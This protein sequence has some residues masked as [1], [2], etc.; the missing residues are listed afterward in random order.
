LKKTLLAAA[1]VWTLPA[2]AAEPTR[3]LVFNIM[4]SGHQIGQH[5]IDITTQ[6]KNTTVDMKTDIEVK[7]MF[8]TA[9][10]LTYTA[11]ETWTNGTFATFQSQTDDNGKQH[12]VTVTATAD[13][14][15]V[16]ADG[17]RAE[18]PKGTLPATFWNTQFLTRKQLIQTETGQVV[19]IKVEDLGAESVKTSVGTTQAKHYRTTGG[20]ERD[21][22]FDA[23]GT[24]VRFQLVGS[25]KSVITS[26]AQ[27]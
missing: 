11:R 25:D 9:Y 2:Q 6:G 15:L 1:V 27:Q 19:P 7:V 4:R 24:P 16:T 26:V 8:V 3:H 13:K 14:V 21:M 23:S 22:W 10:K 5:T 12:Q 20:L 17:K 18:A